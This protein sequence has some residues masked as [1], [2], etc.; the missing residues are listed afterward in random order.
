MEGYQ[1][2]YISAYA[3]QAKLFSMNC[4]NNNNNTMVTE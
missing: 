2:S 1:R 4:K 3:N